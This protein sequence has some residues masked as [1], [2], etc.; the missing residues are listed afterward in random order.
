MRK[1]TDWWPGSRAGQLEMTKLWGEVLGAKAASW[2]IPENVVAKFKDKVQAAENAF[3]IVHNGDTNSSVAKA[4]CNE[5]F[6]KMTGAARDIKRWFFHSPPLKD[7]ELVSLG[8]KPRDRSPTPTGTPTS[9]AIAKTYLMGMAQLGINLV[10]QIGDG[11]DPS[12]KNFRVHYLVRPQGESPPQSP[13]E[14]THSFSTRRKKTFISFD[15]TDSGKVCYLIV[16]IE[17]VEKKGPWG[18]IT[19]AM[20]P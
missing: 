3:H 7:H 19:N 14:F 9:Q 5:A 4:K 6:E 18:P 12:N 11:N 15:Y 8:L 13:K 16:Q 20:I 17:N 2:N 1:S 10:Y